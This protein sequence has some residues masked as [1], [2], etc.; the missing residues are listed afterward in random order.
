M[1]TNIH[2]SVSADDAIRAAFEQVRELVGK[3]TRR[4]PPVFDRQGDLLYIE[5]AVLPT[6]LEDKTPRLGHVILALGETTGHKHQVAETDG[7]S[8]LEAP[9]GAWRVSPTTWDELSD[10]DS[11]LAAPGARYVVA[12]GPVTIVHEEHGAMDYGSAEDTQVIIEVIQQMEYEG[13]RQV[14]PVFD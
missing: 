9:L 6:G 1:A 13:G 12:T 4:T 3:P 8:L 5:R 2:V 14:R 7:V 10:A 11:P